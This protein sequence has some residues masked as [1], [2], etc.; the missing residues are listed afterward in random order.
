ME[1]ALLILLAALV[2]AQETPRS[3]PISGD[4]LTGMVLPVEPVEGEIRLAALRA[5]VD[6][7]FFG[8]GGR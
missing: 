8:A 5:W 3:I 6:G 7:D 2:S 1:G 4:R